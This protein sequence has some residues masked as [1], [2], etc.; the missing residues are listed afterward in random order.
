MPPH[1]PLSRQNEDV[2]RCCPRCG[3]EVRPPDLMHSEWRCD[4]CGPVVPLHR[5]EKN[6]IDVLTSVTARLR[7]ADEPLPLWCPWP[8]PIG[9]IVAG[10]AW[11][12][13]DRDRPRASA[14]AL[15]GPAPLGDGPAELVLVAEEPGIGLG[16]GLAGVPD[17]DPGHWVEQAVAQ[18][19]A[20][21]KVRAAGHPTPLWSIASLED[22][23]ALAGE[24]RG[25]WLVAVAWPAAAGY[26]LTESIMLADLVGSIP[27]EL[28][29]GA[30][31]GRLC[32]H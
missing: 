13:D 9:W 2:S 12:G 30:P 15:T 21:A 17:G 23:S 28:V 19:A 4:R 24:A 5:A 22:R 10:A 1:R 27:P 31:S 18:G 20:T 25:M 8:L 6:S 26:L 16:L 3:D 7:A 14:L 32:A 11:A 29:F